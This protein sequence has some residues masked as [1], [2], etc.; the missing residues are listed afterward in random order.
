MPEQDNDAKIA[1]ATRRV[2]L[3]MVGCGLYW[4]IVMILGDKL[5]L[6]N[7]IR[8]LLDLIALAGFG[9]GLWMTWQLWRLR[10]QDKG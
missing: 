9:Y 2:A 7:R 1:G 3:V 10:L 8:A 5:A 4:I 6:P